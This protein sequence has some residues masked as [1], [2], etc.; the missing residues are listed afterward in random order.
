MIRGFKKRPRSDLQVNEMRRSANPMGRAI[1]LSI[2]AIF[3]VVV[4]NYLFGD[5]V[6]LRADGLV[7][8]D[9]TVIATT[10]V[11]RIQQVE[12]TEGQQVTEGQILLR[13]QS[14]EMLER[15]ADLSAR[16]A[17]L[18]ADHVEFRI[19]SETVAE[20]LPLAKKREDEATRVVGKF[21]QLNQAG[22]TTASSYDTALTANYNAQEDRIK[23][24][25]QLKMLERELTTLQDAREDSESALEKLQSHY[26]EGVITS[27]VA[28]AIGAT[29]PSIGNV[30]RTGDPMLSIFSGDAYV[31]AYLPRRY[32]F[33]ITLGQNVVISDAR[34]SIPGEVAEILPVTD[35]LAKEFQNTFKPRDRSQLAKIKL[36]RPSPFPLHEKVAITARWF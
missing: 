2:L 5:L 25:T 28:G 27:P 23:L 16:R 1:Y 11:A 8:K 30:Y 24:A 33:A 17:R 3:G 20:L 4:L 12:V 19:R 35:A 18:V 9:Q 34:H 26:A 15:L 36:L 21:D 32:L 31:L 14:T 13:L 22:F 29:I 10:Y 7:L 6:L